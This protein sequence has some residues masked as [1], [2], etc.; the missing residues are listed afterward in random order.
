MGKIKLICDSMADLTKDQ[1][2]KYDIEVLPLTVIL[3]DKEYKDGIDFE[4][5]EF[6]QLLKDKKIP[7]GKIGRR[8]LIRRS[9]MEQYIDRI[10]NAKQGN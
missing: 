3:D 2:E 4:L 8:I 1:I 9:D 10:M 7:S 6:Y 5:D